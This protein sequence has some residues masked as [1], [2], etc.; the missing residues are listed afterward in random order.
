MGNSMQ[1]QADTLISCPECRG[2]YFT[3]TMGGKMICKSRISDSDIGC[4]WSGPMLTID[5]SRNIRE[6]IGKIVSE[7]KGL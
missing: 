2:Y 7:A 4:G 6:L 5:D 3:V 1:E